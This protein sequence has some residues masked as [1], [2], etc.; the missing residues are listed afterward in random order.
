[1]IFSHIAITCDDPFMIEDWYCRNLGFKRARLIPLGEDNQ[2][3]FIKNAQNFYMEIFKSNEVPPIS[4]PENDGYPFKGL[5]HIAFQVDDIDEAIKNVT[6]YRVS[7]GPLSFE[8]F[9]PGWR[10][11]WIKD[12]EGNIV[13]ISQGYKDDE[14]IV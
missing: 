11:V 4:S 5:K 2:I 8:D 12:P 9:I 1:M 14:S 10:T 6:D 3:I 7:L 13:E